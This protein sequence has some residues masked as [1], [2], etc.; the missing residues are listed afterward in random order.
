MF[1]SPTQGS[2]NLGMKATIFHT[3]FVRSE[4]FLVNLWSPCKK[5][6]RKVPPAISVDPIADDPQT[7]FWTTE[8]TQLLGL[9]AILICDCPYCGPERKVSWSSGC[10]FED[11]PV[12]SKYILSL[13]KTAF[14]L[15]VL[16]SGTSL[17]SS[18]K[19]SRGSST[20]ITKYLNMIKNGVNFQSSHRLI[21]VYQPAFFSVNSLRI[22]H[23]LWP[24]CFKSLQMLFWL[25]SGTIGGKV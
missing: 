15:N 19:I 13:R 4:F 18:K 14:G 10:Y 6:T 11:W 24:P 3:P 17:A 12:S 16:V 8:N 9:S 2:K 7:E 5:T 22:E 25:R 23:G 1:Y 20:I 21:T